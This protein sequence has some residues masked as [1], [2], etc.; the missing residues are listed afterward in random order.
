M[1]DIKEGFQITLE[2]SSMDSFAGS[3]R[4]EQGKKKRKR[5]EKAPPPSS[6]HGTISTAKELVIRRKGELEPIWTPNPP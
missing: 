4:A 6:G 2:L 5:K 1:V 3:R